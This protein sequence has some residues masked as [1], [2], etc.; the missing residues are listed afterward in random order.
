MAACFF[1]GGMMVWLWMVE[2]VFM[3]EALCP[4]LL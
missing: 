4:F 1:L 2:A 3:A